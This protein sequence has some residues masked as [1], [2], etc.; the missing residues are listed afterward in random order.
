MRNSLLNATFPSAEHRV[1]GNGPA[2]LLKVRV[3]ERERERSHP[4]GLWDN[5]FALPLFIP[6]LLAVGPLSAQHCTSLIHST[7]CLVF[8]TPSALVGPSLGSGH[9]SGSGLPLGV[10][11]VIS[12]YADHLRCFP[13]ICTVFAFIMDF[14]GWQSPAAT[15][16]PRPSGIIDFS[17][18]D[19]SLVPLAQGYRCLVA[20][21]LPFGRAIPQ[22]LAHRAGQSCQSKPTS[23]C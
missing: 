8:L 4:L 16:S 13:T 2:R 1:L 9:F 18:R 11:T 20:F 22:P 19:F 10:A 6:V 21:F 7:V 15:H 14:W 12:F 23:G 3:R 5:H 17:S